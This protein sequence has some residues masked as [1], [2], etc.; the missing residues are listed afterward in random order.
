[1][2][3]IINKLKLKYHNLRLKLAKDIP[4]EYKLLLKYG[5]IKEDCTPI[6]CTKCG[7][8]NL[9]DSN[10]QIGG[11][12]IPDGVLCEFEVICTDCGNTCGHW[13][14]GGWSL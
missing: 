11:Y 7:S 12:N 6:K 8:T 3:T 2:L 14:Y 1:M 10:R 9:E 5:Y 4:A 13:A